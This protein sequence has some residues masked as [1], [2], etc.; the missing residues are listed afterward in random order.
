MERIHEK[1]N[2]TVNRYLP[3]DRIGLPFLTKNQRIMEHQV[4]QG[5]IS[6]DH[7]G[8]TGLWADRNLMEGSHLQVK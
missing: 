8:S 1:N 6:T 5:R 4:S 3:N 7:L 2:S